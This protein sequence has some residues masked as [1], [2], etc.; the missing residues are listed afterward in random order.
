MSSS[1]SADHRSAAT[2]NST[3][4]GSKGRSQGSA[5]SAFLIDLIALLAF[6]LFARLAH[7]D[8]SGFGIG[9]WLDTAWPF[10]VGTVIAWAGL[11]F[12]VLRD[13]S[14]Y[15]LSVGVP[16]WLVSVVVGLVIWGIRHAA[17]PHWSFI[18]VASVTS[19]ILLF[20]WRG[21]ALALNR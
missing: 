11:W 9:R 20:G 6:A 14:G 3:A 12:A 7:D 16:V 15:E 4:S 2:S 18:I 10:M 1:S 19:A 21:I 13:R 8:G 17:I 5:A